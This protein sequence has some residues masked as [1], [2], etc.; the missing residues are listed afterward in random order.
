MKGLLTIFWILDRKIWKD[1]IDTNPYFCTICMLLVALIGAIH[2]GSSMINNIFNI[3]L[4]V[5]PVA[6]L[7]FC[8]FMFG[9]N[10]YESIIAS[11]NYT[12]A[13]GRSMFMLFVTAGLLALGYVSAAVVIFVV[14][15]IVVLWLLANIISTLVFGGPSKGT[16]TD[17]FGRKVEIKKNL[18][19]D[20][21]GDDGHTYTDNHDGT[22][23]RED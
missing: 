22:V 9:L 3:S 2:G 1:K 16:I 20:Y 5:N 6:S 23:T 10:M 19:G 14:V 7:G 21:T 15:A 12:T 13:F 4:D 18:S 11:D 8:V 17:S